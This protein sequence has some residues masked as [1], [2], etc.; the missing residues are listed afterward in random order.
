MKGLKV[1]GI[2]VLFAV[3]GVAAPAFAQEDAKP[4]AKPPEA[5]P[6]QEP[7]PAQ[8]QMKEQPKPSQQGMEKQPEKQQKQAQ[9]NQKQEQKQQQKQAQESQKQQQKQAKQAQKDQAKQHAKAGPPAPQT[10][11]QTRARNSTTVA[12]GGPHGGGRIPD[13]KF[14]AHFGREHTFHV[15]HPTMVAGQPRFQYGGY[16]F[17][18]VDPWPAG[19]SYD[20]NCYIDYVDDGYYL[21][22][23]LYPG[24]RIAIMVVV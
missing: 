10:Q 8:G 14:R 18:L 23:P 7:K 6:Q 21:F 24:V 11:E 1:L 13:D 4:E 5:K 22:D 3:L 16:W 20:D 15:G 12:G 9:E 17:A 19:W 2:A